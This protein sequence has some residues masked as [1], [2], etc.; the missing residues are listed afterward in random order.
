MPIVIAELIV[1]ILLGL[2]VIWTPARYEGSRITS[3]ESDEYHRL[4]RM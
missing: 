2:L 4:R 1:W 3:D